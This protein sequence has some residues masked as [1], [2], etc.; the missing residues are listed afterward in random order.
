[1]FFE[2]KLGRDRWG[3]C[4]LGDEEEAK[5]YVNYLFETYS[6]SEII[7]E[8][9][10]QL[11]EMEFIKS[12]SLEDNRSTSE[13]VKEGL[14]IGKILIDSLSNIP[15][16]CPHCK[17]TFPYGHTREAEI[18]RIPVN[19]SSRVISTNLFGKPMAREITTTYSVH[20]ARLCSDCYKK[21]KKHKFFER[22]KELLLQI[23]VIAAFIGIIFL[24]AFLY[25]L[26]FK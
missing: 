21:H 18:D 1:M 2:S 23:F 26:I 14:K 6:A 12:D 13:R 17:K 11:Q 20:K 8:L 19:K 24:L 15:I 4:I 16:L 22:I 7:E 3:H 5:A 10:Y 25:D 9:E